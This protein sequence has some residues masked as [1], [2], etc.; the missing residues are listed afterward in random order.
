MQTA[1]A[2][3]V[4]RFALQSSRCTFDSQS[5]AVRS[6]S[7]EVRRPTLPALKH[8]HCRDHNQVT[9]GAA[10]A[11][12]F[13]PWVDVQKLCSMCVLS[14]SWNFFVSHDKYIALQ[15]R[16]AKSHVD[17]QTIQPGLGTSYS[18]PP[19]DPYLTFTSPCYK[20]LSAPLQVTQF[21][22]C[23]DT[24]DWLTTTT[25]RRRGGDGCW[26]PVMGKIQITTWDSHGLDLIVI[27]LTAAR[28]IWDL[29]F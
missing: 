23:S 17:T 19:I 21:A 9:S 13:P 6:R 2:A 28:V 8:K 24:A 29:N 4:P 12:S 10:R 16:R 7:D 18:R 14:L 22:Q 11:G 15:G 27:D 20:I 3:A 25:S 26:K 1:A 5:W